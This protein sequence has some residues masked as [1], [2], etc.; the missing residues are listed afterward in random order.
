M[1]D[2]E[3]SSHTKIKKSRITEH[4]YCLFDRYESDFSGLMS[5]LWRRVSSGA[6]CRP[7]VLLSIPV[8]MQIKA[9]R[10]CSSNSRADCC[11][12][13]CHRCLWIFSF[14]QKWTSLVQNEVSSSPQHLSFTTH[15][16]H[17]HS[18]S[19]WQQQVLMSSV[20][21]QNVHYKDRGLFLLLSPPCCQNCFCFLYHLCG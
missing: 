14:Q 2:A 20:I 5:C 13:A 4:L 21:V 10:R 12:L 9:L 18:S 8:E 16:F 19:L 11:T 3:S 6:C 1:I 17:F 15:G 7:V